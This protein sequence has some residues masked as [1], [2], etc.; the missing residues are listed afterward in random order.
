MLEFHHGKHHKTYVDTLNEFIKRTGFENASLEDIVR[1]S[2]DTILN[3][4]A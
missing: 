2:E 3:N 1:S 4:A